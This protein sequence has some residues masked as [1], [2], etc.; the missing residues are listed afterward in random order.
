MDMVFTHH[1]F[2]NADFKGFARLSDQL[3]NPLTYLSSQYLVA[4]FRDPDKVIFDL[5]DRVT[6]IAIVHFFASCK[7]P[8]IPALSSKVDE[9][10]PPERWEF[11]PWIW[12]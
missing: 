1:P 4:I 3:A 2:K 9:I 12:K 6:A 7:W 10:C 5:E 11:Q 8:I